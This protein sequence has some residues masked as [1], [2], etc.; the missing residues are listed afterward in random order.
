[1]FQ[2]EMCLYRCTL[3]QSKVCKGPALLFPNGST[4]CYWL[5]VHAVLYPVHNHTTG[6]CFYSFSSITYHSQI[7]PQYFSPCIFIMSSISEYLKALTWTKRN[8]GLWNAKVNITRMLVSKSF[9]MG[10]KRNYFLFASQEETASRKP[11]A[12]LMADFKPDRSLKCLQWLL[13]Q[14]HPSLDYIPTDIICFW[15]KQWSNFNCLQSTLTFS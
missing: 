3:I 8:D 1:M 13:V 7:L 4:R 6:N 14:I 2:E 9:N 12:Q 11:D 5:L 15:T 10:R